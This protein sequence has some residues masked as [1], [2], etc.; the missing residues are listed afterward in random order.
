MFVPKAIFFDL[1]GVLIDSEPKN[2]EIWGKTIEEVGI[3]SISF[4]LKVFEGKT[5]KDTAKL[6][7]KFTEEK[8]SVE[9]ILLIHKKFFKE[10][11]INVKPILF[12]EDLINLCLSKNL[13][14][15]IVTSSSGESFNKK[16]LEHPWLNKITEKILGDNNKLKN[17]KPFPDPYLL[18]A[19]NL[20]EKPNQ[21]FAIEDSFFGVMSAFNAG[22]F[23]I[24]YD[25][26][27]LLKGKLLQEKF[28]I[29]SARLLFVKSHKEVINL[30]IN[31]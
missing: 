7:S 9:D 15:A 8:I 21:C 11:M 30:L 20:N 14:I 1:D 18:A 23:V 12:A 17:R 4:D 13:K 22:C 16:S 19:L 10:I 3:D 29:E 25:P 28:D 27:Y 26:E 6:I 24:C 5:R 2:R 31:H